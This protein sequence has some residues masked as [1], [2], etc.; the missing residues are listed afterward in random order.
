MM[1]KATWKYTKYR[2]KLKHKVQNHIT[3]QSI[4]CG[5]QIQHNGK[6]QRIWWTFYTK[7]NA[8]EMQSATQWSTM[9]WRQVANGWAMEINYKMQDNGSGKFNGNAIN[10]QKIKP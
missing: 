6:M 5:R 9:Q 4:T 1:D 7:C 8:M 10:K 3:K 2:E